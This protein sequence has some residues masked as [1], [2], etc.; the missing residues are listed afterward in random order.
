MCRRSISHLCSGSSSPK[1]VLLG[2]LRFS[3]TSV[4]FYHSGQHDIL[5]DLNLYKNTSCISVL[6]YTIWTGLTW[7]RIGSSGGSS[8]IRPWTLGILDSRTLVDQ[9]ISSQDRI[10][11]LVSQTGSLRWSH[12]YLRTKIITVCWLAVCISD[13]GVYERWWCL[14]EWWLPLKIAVVLNDS[15][16]LPLR[17]L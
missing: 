3:E 8:W 10:L 16:T 5:E 7:R 14:V 1:V 13:L 15:V 11:I 2:L 17:P 6:Y 12:K 9:L 4:T